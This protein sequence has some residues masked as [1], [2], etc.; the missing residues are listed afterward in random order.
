MQI[1]FSWTSFEAFGIL[2]LFMQR[3]VCIT[4][5]IFPIISFTGKVLIHLNKNSVEAKSLFG[6]RREVIYKT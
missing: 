3:S 2:Y 5:T 4:Q 6:P 1:L